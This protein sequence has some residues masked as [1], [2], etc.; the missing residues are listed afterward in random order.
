MDVSDARARLL[1]EHRAHILDAYERALRDRFTVLRLVGEAE[2]DDA[3]RRA[4]AGAFGWNEDAA[5]AVLGL[6][7]RHVTRSGRAR[8]S[9]ELEHARRSLA[10][11]A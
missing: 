7:I 1:L 10:S 5:T 2:D 3:A 6:P 8:I 11:L 9:Q 4:L